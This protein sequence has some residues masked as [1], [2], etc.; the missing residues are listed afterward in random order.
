VAKSAEV[1]AWFEALDHPLKDAMLQVRR[2]ILGS[3]RRITET[4]KWRSPTFM[5]EGNIASI[6][7]RSKK[8][9]SVL[10]HQGAS[11]PGKHPHLEGVGGTVRYMRFADLDEVKAKR[12]GLEAAIRAGCELNAAKG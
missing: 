2:I 3:D 10:F 6:E 9:V 12:A 7:P 8:R 4:I 1:E 11:L 5:L